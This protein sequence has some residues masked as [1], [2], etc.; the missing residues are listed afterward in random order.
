MLLNGDQSPSNS[1]ETRSC[2][3]IE[4]LTFQV[5][6]SR[7]MPI[8]DLLTNQLDVT[9]S[10]NTLRTEQLTKCLSLKFQEKKEFNLK[11]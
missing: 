6:N 4:A 9:S 2:K 10:A 5:P 8:T 7:E 1:G 3:S 11:S